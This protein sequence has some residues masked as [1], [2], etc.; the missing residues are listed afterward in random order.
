MIKKK[1]YI[2]LLSFLDT[3]SIKDIIETSRIPIIFNNMLD[4]W[5][6]FKWNLEKWNK[7]FENQLLDCRKGLIT[8]SKVGKFKYYYY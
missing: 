1:I 4:D 2:L 7:L 8:C 3:H 5:E 6:P